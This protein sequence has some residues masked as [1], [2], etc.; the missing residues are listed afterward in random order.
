MRVTLSAVELREEARAILSRWDSCEVRQALDIFHLGQRIGAW[1]DPSPLSPRCAAIWWKLV[2][3][4]W[5][6]RKGIDGRCGRF[7]HAIFKASVPGRSHM[8]TANERRALAS[9]PDRIRIWRGANRPLAFGNDG[10]AWT[11]DRQRAL[12]FA[13]RSS[14]LRGK[15][16]LGSAWIA[17]ENVIAFFDQGDDD[18]S[19]QE[20]VV[21]PEHL[22]ELDVT[23]L[24]P[25]VGFK[26]F[27]AVSS[28]EGWRASI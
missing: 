2:S 1:R 6:S 10:M 14:V 8:M 23:V 22:E 11:I 12:W 9:F 7:W 21:L 19:E 18:A 25:G 5:T 17:R 4:E 28:G 16:R 26:A 15:P 13:R 24:R 20:I 27:D 3:D